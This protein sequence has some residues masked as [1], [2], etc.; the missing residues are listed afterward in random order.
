MYFE[1]YTVCSKFET[2]SQVNSKE[3]LMLYSCKHIVFTF[4][5][6]IIEKPDFIML[7]FTKEKVLSRSY[8]L[9]GPSRF[10]ANHCLYADSRG[11]L[12][13]VSLSKIR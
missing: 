12:C 13:N 4:N 11:L 9:K 6:W 7:R 5:I 8:D 1:F 10:Y 3:K 2:E